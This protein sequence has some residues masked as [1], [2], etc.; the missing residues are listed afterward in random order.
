[1]AQEEAYK[2][3]STVNLCDR[4][5]QK[6]AIPSVLVLLTKKNSIERHEAVLRSKS[7]TEQSKDMRLR[8]AKPDATL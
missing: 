6:T 5:R 3:W 1:M 4:H 7:F 8:E 2:G